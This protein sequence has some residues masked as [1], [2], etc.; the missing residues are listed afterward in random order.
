MRTEPMHENHRWSGWPGA[1]CLYCGCAD[2]ME[3]EL[4]HIPEEDRA[5]VICPAT[6]EQ[7]M[8]VDAA[9]NPQE[10]QNARLRC[11]RGREAAL[12]QRDVPYH[13]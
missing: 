4:A 12:R 3:E 8:V 7:K 9:L 11:L 10:A 1:H 6:K 5:P 13:V 2:P